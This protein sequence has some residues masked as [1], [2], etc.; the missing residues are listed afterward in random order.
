MRR[1]RAVLVIYEWIIV[2]IVIVVFILSFEH[3]VGG[4]DFVVPHQNPLA[5][6]QL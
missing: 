3:F 1:R 5:S 2:F 4:F 6:S